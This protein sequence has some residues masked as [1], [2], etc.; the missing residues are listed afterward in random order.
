MILMTSLHVVG[1]RKSGSTQIKR[2]N[3]WTAEEHNVQQAQIQ[4]SSLEVLQKKNEVMHL[5]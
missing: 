5:V 2:E 4:R 1:K 3:I